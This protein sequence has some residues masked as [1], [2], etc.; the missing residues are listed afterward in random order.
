[1]DSG[2]WFTI[3]NIDKEALAYIFV[4]DGADDKMMLM[5]PSD[6]VKSS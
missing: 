2:G 3:K 5:Y 4:I 6:K 1:M